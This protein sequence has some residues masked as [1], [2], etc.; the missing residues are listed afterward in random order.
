MPLK[1][2]ISKWGVL[3][4]V[5]DYSTLQ[6]AH[7]TNLQGAVND[8]SIINEFLLMKLEI[9]KTNIVLLIAPR[10]NSDVS[11]PEARRP[12]GTNVREALAEIAK[13]GRPGDFV[14]VH[15]SGWTIPL[16]HDEAALALMDEHL[17]VIDFVQHLNDIANKGLTVLMT[18]DA[19]FSGLGFYQDSEQLQSSATIRET[20]G[21]NLKSWHFSPSHNLNIIASCRPGEYSLERKF[22]GRFYGLFTLSLVRSLES[23]YRLGRMGETTYAT[24]E[25]LLLAELGDKTKQHPEFRG[26]KSRLLFQSNLAPDDLLSGVARVVRAERDYIIINRGNISAMVGDTYRIWNPVLG[27]KP[28]EGSYE[29]KLTRVHN[30][31]SMALPTQQH[32]NLRD[33]AGWLAQLVQRDKSNKLSVRLIWDTKAVHH[34]LI[35][36]IQEIREALRRLDQSSNGAPQVRLVF[37]DDQNPRDSYPDLETQFYVRILEQN[38]RPHFQ[39]LNR[40]MEP[41]PDLP[42]LSVEEPTVAEKLR[43]LILHLNSFTI[44]EGVNSEDLEPE[45]VTFEFEKVATPSEFDNVVASYKFS[46]QL[47]EAD[48]PKITPIFYTIFNINPLYGFRQIIPSLGWGVV[49]KGIELGNHA[50]I[51]DFQVPKA[52]TNNKYPDRAELP[53]REILKIFISRER[54]DLSYFRLRN[55]MDDNGDLTPGWSEILD[56]QALSSSFTIYH[57][58]ILITCRQ[59]EQGSWTG[60]SS[61]VTGSSL[62]TDDG[63]PRP[64]ASEINREDQDDQ[65]DQEDQ[66]HWTELHRAS[67]KN[68]KN[69]VE[70]IILEKSLEK[71]LEKRF[72]VNQQLQS[73]DHSTPLHIAARYGSKD[74]VPVLLQYG[75]NIAQYTTNRKSAEDIARDHG[76][77]YIAAF[78][79]C[80]PHLFFKGMEGDIYWRK[81]DLE[82]QE[83][84]KIDQNQQET[85]RF[86]EGSFWT[87][88]TAEVLTVESMLYRSNSYLKGIAGTAS[89]TWV[90][91]PSNNVIF[92]S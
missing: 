41:F 4:G 76:H 25:Y 65:E 43:D 85:T 24:L 9:P 32:A 27:S 82:P 88:D 15:F 81:Q 8:V 66:T 20:P 3:I 46:I 50:P 90:H 52:L 5:D 1:Q 56:P 28:P 12:T 84:S 44:M 70:S 37:Q 33:V 79:R 19:A 75:A 53:M 22:H 29:V 92:T 36:A 31:E 49:G 78:L 74:V 54:K 10:P 89:T 2:Q 61:V 68:E 7:I 14:F 11:V 38:L 87:K 63:R 40:K 30:E 73:L 83:Q 86:F 16:P 17:P 71:S 39:F 26:K 57:R 21:T 23:L 34:G 59:K 64:I 18:L 6:T 72:N 67:A 55:V 77:T 35:N 13:R 42:S 48:T 45:S 51:I 80:I 47:H 91:L 60:I 69:S 62:E 58:E